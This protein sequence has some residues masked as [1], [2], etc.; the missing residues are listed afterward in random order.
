[1]KIKHILTLFAGAM[2]AFTSCV[3]EDPVFG[4]DDAFVATPS[5]INVG[6]DGGSQTVEINTTIAWSVETNADWITVD[7]KSGVNAAKIT[8]TVAKNEDENARQASVEVKSMGNSAFIT[9]K[10]AAGG[11]EYGTK[12]HPY[13]ASKAYDF[14]AALDAGAESDEVYITGIIAKI[15]EK[16]GTQYGN[17][18]FYITD[19]GQ[20][21]DKMFEVYR[22]LYLGN[23]KY[24]NEADQNI[25]L[26]DK[27]LIYGKCTNYKGNTPETVQNASYVVSIEEGTTPILE[28][29]EKTVTVSS[30]VTSAEF[31]LTVKNLTA[32]W[33][34]TPAE[35]YDW[36]T[37][38]TK[39]GKESG[40][41]SFTLT[42]NEGDPRTAKFTV[43]STGAQSVELTL[44]QNGAVLPATLAELIASIPETATGSS[45]KAGFEA[46]LKEAAVVTYVNGGTAYIED[47]TG[48]VILYKTDHGLVAGNT[49][50]GKISGDCYWYNGAPEILGLGDAYEKGEGAA[51][52]PK[53]ITLAELN[54]NYAANLIRFVTIKGVTVSD[55]I[56]DGD[57]NGEITQGEAKL[58]VYAQINNGGLSLTAGSEG[59]ITGIVGCYYKGDTHTD[60]LLFWDNAW[61]NQTGGPVEVPEMYL[62]EFDCTNK[63]IEI[64]N[65]TDAE[66]DMTGWIL[67]KNDGEEGDKDTFVIPAA[68]AKVPAKGF[69][70][71]TCKQ[72]DA[73]NGPLFGISGKADKGFK[74]AL[75]MGTN[76]VDV[77]DNLTTITEI[78]DGKSWGRETDGAEN[79]VIFD[80]P[81]IGESNGA[82]PAPP[83]PTTIAELVAAI[84]STATGS[85][86]AVTVDVDF[87]N[88][89]TVSY[90]N[91]NN[92]YI[93]DAT[94]GILLF[95]SGHGLQAGVT[96]KGKLTV[97]GYWYNGIPELVDFTAGAETVV[98]AG[99]VPLAEVT[100]AELLADYNKYLLR[101][102]KLTGVTV[103]DGI[104]DGDRNGEIQQGD[105]KIAVYAQLKEKG[106]LLTQGD[107]GN[108]ITIPGLY[109]TTKQV[110]FWDNA[111]WE[112]TA[113]DVPPTIT[114]ADITG[115]PA[116]GV[117]DET[118]TVSFANADGWTAS[119]TPDGTVVTAA[120]IDGTTIKYTVAE[121]T[122]TEAR[123][124]KITIALKKEGKDDVTKEIKVSQKAAEAALDPSKTYYKKVTE[125]PADWSGKYLLVAD[126]NDINKAFKGFS[127]TSTVYGEGADVTITSSAIESTETTDAYQIVIAK[128]TVTE[129][130]YTIKFGDNFFTWT[131]GNSLNKANA[132]SVNTNWNITYVTDHA[133]I[134]NAADA[135][136]NLQWNAASPRFACYGND[137]QTV[138]QLYKLEE[139]ETPATGSDVP[140]YDPITGFTW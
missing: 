118:A 74:I 60:Q 88:E 62:N 137:N 29:A 97:K 58:A 82:A 100:I 79:F 109:N 17:A 12:E 15:D 42:V 85:S 99:S 67:L 55:G 28:V 130:A 46:N 116:A 4:G 14:A 120:S 117:T 1:M 96:I 72:S 107:Q 44:T 9:V 59:D 53:E 136:R 134:R 50:K 2:L 3:E 8:V 34:V 77:V 11:I 115:V 76:V 27:V 69:A 108:L 92:A 25:N 113:T 61:F 40:K 24:D 37:D 35:T 128:A 81:T 71:F 26:G 56:A 89:A 126:N 95:K 47:A 131:S 102:V 111:W 114:A 38:Y 104:A 33:T 21:S 51:P 43:A 36:I 93:E 7:P 84:P 52:A 110:Y 31:D 30:D 16:F 127:S 80:T 138:I 13:P 103:T 22:T 87:A 48:A 73:A 41:I 6:K 68:L 119:V 39:S 129:G 78:P 64:Y 139:S 66:V 94:G 132:E 101:R 140:D 122:A 54:A 121:N 83:A 45:T 86:T 90:V 75:M 10:Q 57:R 106:L 125:A 49:I 135:T 20:P 63:K 65:A 32:D 98:G 23:K 70:V 19:D 5:I 133:V 91:G 112:S 105:N 123:D 124:G 18:T